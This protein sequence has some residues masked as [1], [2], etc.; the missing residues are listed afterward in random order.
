[1]QIQLQQG[2]PNDPIFNQLRRLAKQS[3]D[4]LFHDEYGVDA[5]YSDLIHDVIHLREILR[6]HLPSAS[7]DEQGCLREDAK[8]IAFLAYSGYSF[9][10]SFFAIAAL[11][12]ICVP[13]STGLNPD[14]AL[15]F[16]K[17]VKAVYILTE[18]RTVDM[19]MTFTEHARNEGQR[20]T[21]IPITRANPAIATIPSSTELEINQE[22]TFP[23]TAGCLILFT[24]GTT[25]PPKGVVL[26]RKMF[27]F[28]EGI[29]PATLYLASCPPHWVGG[30][31]LID[32]VLIGEN[33]HMLKSEAPPARFWELLREGRVTE[34]AISPTLLRRLMEY[35]QENIC[36]LAAQK[37]NEYID[38]AKKL[39]RVI[40]SGSMLNPS[41]WRFFAALTGMPIINGYG[42]TEMGGG[43][44]INP[45]G[46]VYEQGYIGKVIPGITVKLSHGDHGEILVKSPIRFSH[47]IGDEAATRAAFDEEGFYKTGDQAHRVGDDYYFDGRISS[48]F[49]RFHEYTI[50]IPELERQLLELPY[51]TEAHVLPVKDHG[52]GGLVAAL[53]RLRKQEGDSITLKRIRND[54]AAMNLASY[55]L[56]TLLRIL[57][58]EEQVPLTPSEKVLKRECLREF[59]HISEYIPDPYAVEGV[60][61]CGNQ[62]DLA[63]SSRVF[64]WGGL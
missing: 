17:K 37:R 14:E 63:A 59:F 9:I 46:S 22:S 47:Y 2:F 27:H 41:T 11:G 23:E 51:I 6:E 44:I 25:G 33:L 13:L 42:I 57:R 4:V 32:S 12:G 40:V 36:H 64:D 55:K 62:L 53:V 39:E 10:I 26:P 60:E 28:G 8:S 34:M 50:S 18:K 35:Y 61:Y 1:M 56:P 29:T 7:F 38:G 5:R 24:S 43:V 52:A 48:D 21:L 58:N 15:Y 45:P 31:G 16:L 54:L 49:V 30:T 20:V 19:A 3:P